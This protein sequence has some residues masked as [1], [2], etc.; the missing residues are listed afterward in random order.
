M[1][2]VSV[3]CFRLFTYNIVTYTEISVYVYLLSYS[4]RDK[5]VW[6]L[7][8]SNAFQMAALNGQSSRLDPPESGTTA[9]VLVRSS[10]TI[11]FNF[12]RF[13]NA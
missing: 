9:K 8:Y 4:M 3:F 7:L 13:K 5:T 1:K 2:F 11:C 6:Y 12:N 10:T